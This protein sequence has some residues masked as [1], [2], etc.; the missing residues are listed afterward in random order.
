LARKYRGREVEIP[1]L[2]EIPNAARN[3]R[4]VEVIVGEVQTLKM[5]QPEKGA[6]GVD[7]TIETTATK[8]KSNHTTRILI[9][10]DTIP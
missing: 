9:T 5:N 3:L 10:L 6:A 2:W 7:R 1:E 8:I 4:V